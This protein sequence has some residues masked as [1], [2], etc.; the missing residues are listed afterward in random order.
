M[1]DDVKELWP[2]LGWIKDE[3]LRMEPPGASIYTH[4]GIGQFQEHVDQHLSQ[5]WICIEL[6]INEKS[7]YPATLVRQLAQ[8]AL[9]IVNNGAMQIG[10]GHVNA[11]RV[12]HESLEVVLRNESV[13]HHV[14]RSMASEPSTEA[15]RATR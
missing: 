5:V 1:P 11:H 9:D 8:Y 15:I 7:E 6:L 14:T 3:Q 4:L 10:C 13:S 2:E 12:I